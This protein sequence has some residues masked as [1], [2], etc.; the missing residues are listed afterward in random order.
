MELNRRIIRQRFEDFK[1]SLGHLARIQALSGESV[2]QRKDLKCSLEREM[3]AS[4][5]FLNN[6][7]GNC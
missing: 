3:I 7:S 6:S 2:G 1:E 4:A 5:N